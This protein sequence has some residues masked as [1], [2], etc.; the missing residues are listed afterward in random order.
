MSA[1]AA[2]R[3]VG[4]AASRELSDILR[5]RRDDIVARWMDRLTEETHARGIDPTELRDS[6]PEYLDRLADALL[7]ERTAEEQGSSAWTDLAREHALTRAR[8]GFDVEQLLFEFVLL[9]RVMFDVLCEEG[10][11]GRGAEL[12]RV[13]DL[14]EAAMSKAV[15]NYVEARN[16]SARKQTA[17]HV[18]FITHELRNPLTTALLITTQLRRTPSLNPKVAERLGVLER[19]LRKQEALIAGVLEAERM[20]AGAITP[21]FVTM[22]LADVLEPVLTA[23]RPAAAEKRL[24]LTTHFDG[25]LRVC[26]DRSMIHG[27][28]HNLLENAIK[29]TDRGRIDVTV[30]RS[31]GDV[32]FHVRDCCGGIPAAEMRTL[33]EPFKR[34]STHKPGTGLGLSIARRAVEAQGGVIDVESLPGEGCHFWFTLPD[35]PLH[36][37]RDGERP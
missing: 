28:L 30:E 1:R 17:E 37:R 29:Y 6:I 5:K 22:K 25:E 10:F 34:G 20:E 15:K 26:A 21:Q 27:V 18:G 33:F 7:D 4:E 11:G 2:A 32:V 16:Y 8:V 14:M 35:K 12:A 19:A 24:T 31:D 36:E 3:L 9:R 13:A 23:A